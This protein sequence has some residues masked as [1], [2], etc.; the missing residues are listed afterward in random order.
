MTNETSSDLAHVAEMTFIEPGKARFYVLDD[1]F[2]GLE[3]DGADKKRVNLHRALPVHNPDEYICVLDTEGK[4]IG[5]IRTLTGFSSEQADLINLELN[6]RYYSPS[7]SR[8][9][10]AKEK[11]GYVYFELETTAG[12]RSIAVK[13]ISRSIRRLDDKRILILDVDGNRYLI[14]DSLALDRASLKCIESYL[15]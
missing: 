12:R 10:S 3:Y 14:Q 7:I 6:R 5:I 15:F 13:D 2:L 1:D 8:I 4:E 11:M 9:I